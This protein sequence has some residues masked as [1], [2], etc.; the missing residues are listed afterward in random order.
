MHIGRVLEMAESSSD[1]YVYENKIAE[2]FGG[3]IEPE[4][5]VPTP[6]VIPAAQIEDS[7]L[8]RAAVELAW[9]DN[10]NEEAAS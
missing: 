5:V 9:K 1:K 2:W 6:S 4:L 7:E 8:L 3:Q 10:D